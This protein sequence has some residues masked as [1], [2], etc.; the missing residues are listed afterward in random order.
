MAVS[1]PVSRIP[2]HATCAYAGEIFAVWTWPQAMYDGTTKTFEM[3]KRCPTVQVLALNE[4]GEVV[5]AQQEQPHVAT[6]Y[7]S[8]CGGRM[9]AG[10]E[11]LVAA[12]RELLEE[13][14]MVSDVWELVQV[15]VGTGKMEWFIYTYI[16]RNCRK[17]AEQMLDGGEKI[18]VK[19]A[20]V[21]TF[22][23]EILTDK[24][25]WGGE[26]KSQL[27]SAW[28]E[29]KVLEWTQLLRGENQ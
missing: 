3:L 23:R 15:D 2:A 29:S 19:T 8:L 20:P 22:L 27:F 16:A 24:T 25:F 13:T 10:E 14:G 1:L 18:T 6:P 5:Y 28:N 12:K 11:P 7:L 26:L 21:D 17:V 4:A 9:D